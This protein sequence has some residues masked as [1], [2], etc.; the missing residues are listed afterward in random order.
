VFTN[1]IQTVAVAVLIS[2]QLETNGTE[3]VER[4]PLAIGM[5]SVPNAK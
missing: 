2:V 5:Q 1:F 3:M 4:Q